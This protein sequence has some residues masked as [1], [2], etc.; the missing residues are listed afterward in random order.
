M[1]KKELIQSIQ[2]INSINPQTRTSILLAIG[3]SD[4]SLA[5]G[6]FHE[7]F[8]S[9]PEDDVQIDVMT[10]NSNLVDFINEYN[11]LDEDENYN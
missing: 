9:L 4:Y 10:A 3:E 8:I 6:I 11:L 1:T 2:N 5:L 7:L